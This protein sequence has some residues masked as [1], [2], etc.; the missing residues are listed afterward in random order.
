MAEKPLRK[1]INKIK[2][3]STPVEEAKD[4]ETCAVFQIFRAIAGAGDERTRRLAEDYRAPGMG[5]GD[6]KRRLFELI[7]DHFGPAR[8]RREALMADPGQVDAVLAAGAERA[9]A[10]GATVLA[11]ARSAC[12]L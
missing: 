6:A 7:L 12:G 8:A 9:G 5:Y 10:I 4:P 1:R 11:R 3:D 2:T